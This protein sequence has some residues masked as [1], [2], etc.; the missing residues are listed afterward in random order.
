MKNKLIVIGYIGSKTCFLNM[1][2]EEAIKLYNEIN[3]D[4]NLTADDVE[5]TEFEFDNIFDA[6]DAYPAEWLPSRKLV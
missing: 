2:K 5:V 4:V 3:R 1:P 6:Y